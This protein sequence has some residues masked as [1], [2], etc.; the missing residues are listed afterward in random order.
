LPEIRKEI[1]A[2]LFPIIAYIGTASTCQTREEEG[3]KEFTE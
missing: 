1:S 2:I 3:E